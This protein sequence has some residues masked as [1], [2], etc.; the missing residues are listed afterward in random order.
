MSITVHYGD[1]VLCLPASVLSRLGDVNGD[2]L[3]VLL[4]LAAEP[5]LTT[6]ELASRLDITSKKVTAAMSFWQE[7]GLISMDGTPS[8]KT[9]SSTAAAAKQQADESSAIVRTVQS[10]PKPAPTIPRYTT[11]EL[12]TLLETR[13]ELSELVDECSRVFGKVLNTHEVGILLGIVDHLDVSGEYLL[14]VLAHCVTMGK[15]SMRYVETVA[16]SLYDEGITDTT[17]LEERLK[18]KEQLAAVEGKI[19]TMFGINSRALTSKE[20][21]LIEGWLSTMKFDLDVI[22]RAYEV[23]VDAIGK[24][25]IP[26]ANSIME[27]WAAAGLHTLKEIETA[28]A[29]HA[30]QGKPTTAGNSFN[31][32]DFFGD[33]LKRSFGEDFVPAPPPK[34]GKK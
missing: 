19:R 31:T 17:M 4:C 16:L 9:K 34:S 27:R 26:Y 30:A 2:T 20:K 29:E 32:A 25:S 8:P 12:A 15:R 24:P 11:D 5:D 33:A 28:D 23:T 21:K 22:T 7:A 6:E 1:G 10:A 18:Q 3:K 14:L 13:R